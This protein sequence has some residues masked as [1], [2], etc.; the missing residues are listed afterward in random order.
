MYMVGLFM[1]LS[2]VAI[3]IIKLLEIIKGLS[4]SFW[5]GPTSRHLGL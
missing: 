2:S 4:R 5:G 1:N 3:T